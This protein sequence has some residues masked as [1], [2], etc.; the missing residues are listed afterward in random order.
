[1]TICLIPRFPAHSGTC[2][3]Y[4]CIYPFLLTTIL[5]QMYNSYSHKPRCTLL[6]D[7]L[8]QMYDSRGSM[9]SMM[10]NRSLPHYRGEATNVL[11]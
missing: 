8:S 1:M 3:A 2:E 6:T 11:Q 10:K 4:H 5:F 7:A 9:M